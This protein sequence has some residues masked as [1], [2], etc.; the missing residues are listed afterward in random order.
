MSEL[1]IERFNPSSNV[2]RKAESMAEQMRSPSSGKPIRD[3]ALFTGWLS[4]SIA[5]F[6]EAPR[7]SGK[8]RDRL[9]ADLLMVQIL[10]DKA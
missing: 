9:A 2:R 1:A 8:A 10:Q 7:W 4:A 6:L 5:E 3:Y